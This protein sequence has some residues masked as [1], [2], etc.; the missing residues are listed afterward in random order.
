MNTASPAPPLS[1]RKRE[2]G[3]M[4]GLSSSSIDALIKQGK[5]QF[6]KCGD[7]K[8]SSVL[9]PVDCLKKFIEENTQT[10]A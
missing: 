6:V 2:A 1:V 8:R 7:R 4:V 5:L 3:R 10:C 9:I